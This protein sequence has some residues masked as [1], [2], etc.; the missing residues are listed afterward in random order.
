MR[1]IVI[2]I[3]GI[4]T[5]HAAQMGRVEDDHVVETFAPD[6]ADQPLDIT[7]LPR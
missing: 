3:F 1:P 5:Q 2:V 7:V 4:A 6:G